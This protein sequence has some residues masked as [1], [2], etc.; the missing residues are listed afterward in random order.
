MIII[1]NLVLYHTFGNRKAIYVCYVASDSWVYIF[2]GNFN[3]KKKLST[4][5]LEKI[6]KFLLFDAWR[7]VSPNVFRDFLESGLNSDIEDAL[8]DIIFTKFIDDIHVKYYTKHTI[9]SKL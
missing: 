5:F 7:I 1:Y 4:Q 3:L 9:I 8:W 2:R 6:K